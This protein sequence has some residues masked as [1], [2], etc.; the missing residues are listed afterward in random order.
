MYRAAE[1][2]TAGR[3]GVLMFRQCPVTRCEWPTAAILLFIRH[4]YVL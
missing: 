1:N 4:I 2:R 3:A